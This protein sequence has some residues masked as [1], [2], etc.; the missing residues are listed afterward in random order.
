MEL[1]FTVV[2]CPEMGGIVACRNDSIGGSICTQGDTFAVLQDMMMD[3]VLWYFEVP[4]MPGRLQLH[5]TQRP[6]LVIG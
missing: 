2:P 6:V 3:A 4:A 5:F 1:V